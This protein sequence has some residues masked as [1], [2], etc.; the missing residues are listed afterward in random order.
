MLM[1]ITE[2]YSRDRGGSGLAAVRLIVGDTE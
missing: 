2:V 1:R